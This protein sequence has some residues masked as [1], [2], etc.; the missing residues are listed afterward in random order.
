M[1]PRKMI[2]PVL[3]KLFSTILRPDDNNLRH[4]L[5]LG[6]LFRSLKGAKAQHDTTADNREMTP[7]A[8]SPYLFDALISL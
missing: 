3:L 7:G 2:T 8:V 5:R 4:I 1:N 6:R